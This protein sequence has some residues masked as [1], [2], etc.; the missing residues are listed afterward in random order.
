M[1]TMVDDTR[2]RWVSC[3]DRGLHTPKKK[4]TVV[5]QEVEK[6]MVD[7]KHAKIDYNT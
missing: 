6:S 3:E 4:G 2:Q 7:L 1:K 5:G